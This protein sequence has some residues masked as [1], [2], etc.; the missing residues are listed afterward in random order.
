MKN[1][2]NDPAKIALFIADKGIDAPMRLLT[3]GSSASVYNATRA[4]IASINKVA[5]LVTGEEEGTQ[6]TGSSSR[7][8]LYAVSYDTGAGSYIKPEKI[9][10]GRKVKKPPD[11]ALAQHAFRGWYTDS[12]FAGE[13]DFESEITRNITLY[14]KWEQTAATVTFNSRQGTAI[15]SLSVAIGET[16]TPPAP[17]TRNGYAFE[18]WCTDS[19]AQNVFNFGNAI[20]ANMTLYARWK[21]VYAVSFTGNGGSAVESQTVDNGGRVVY[22]PIPSRENYLFGVW[23]TDPQLTAEYNFNSPVTG[24]F[25]L[26]AKWTRVS[27]NVTFDSNGGSAVPEQTVDI[28]GKAAK[29]DN[30]EREGYNFVRWCSDPG[31]TQEFL[32]TNIPVNYP[33]VLYAAWTIKTLTVEFNC[34]GGSFVDNQS[35]EYGKLAVYP[36]TPVKDGCLFA[37][38]IVIEEIEGE[39]SGET[40]E[41]RREYEFSA[42]V[43]GNMTLCAEWHEGTV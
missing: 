37:R 12:G 34:G 7:D 18:Y 9:I 36:I 2:G 24:N 25:A 20:I 43:V 41:V 31:L 42:P 30:P 35:I 27:N 6:R 39:E 15:Q 29:P 11:P 21:T 13:Y 38:W 4:T 26:Y 17:P 22:P 19:A 5:A 1:L 8:N 28:G 23:C 10:Y 14:A 40:E 16:A 33:T 3:G 32:F